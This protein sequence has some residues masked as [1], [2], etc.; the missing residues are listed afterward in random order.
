MD[1]DL[2]LPNQFSGKYAPDFQ[3]LSGDTQGYD[4]SISLPFF[5]TQKKGDQIST[6]SLHAQQTRK[7][8]P[9]INYPSI[10]LD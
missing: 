3:N 5:V 8:C 2:S 7:L 9:A 6:I 4:D 1:F 10:E